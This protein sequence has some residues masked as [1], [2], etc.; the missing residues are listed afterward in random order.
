[1]A[2]LVRTEPG[3]FGLADLG[4]T[5]A[6]H[7]ASMQALM[8]LVSVFIGWKKV[9]AVLYVL[10][11]GWMVWQMLRWVSRASKQRCSPRGGGGALLCCFPWRPS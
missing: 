7:P 2:G 11:A 6:R 8:T 5:P 3:S 1:M 4:F 9:A 10:L